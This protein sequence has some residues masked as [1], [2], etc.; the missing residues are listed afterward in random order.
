VSDRWNPA[1]WAA[2]RDGAVQV[3]TRLVLLLWV[4]GMLSAAEPSAAT[5]EAQP[6]DELIEGVACVNDPS[7]TYTLYLPPGYDDQKDGD[8]QGRRPLMLIFDPPG[9]SVIEALRLDPDEFQRHP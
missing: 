2:L 1:R 4:A 7:Q 8:E 5:S 9:R 6:P 3:M